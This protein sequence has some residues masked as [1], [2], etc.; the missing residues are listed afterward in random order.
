[1]TTDTPFEIFLVC[2]PGLEAPLQAEALAKGFAVSG[3]SS[4]GVT[5]TGGWPDVWRANLELRGA[6]RVLVRVGGFMAFH[7]AQLD[8]RSRKFAWGDVLRADV[9]VKVQV[10][11]K[12]SKIYH[13]GAATQRIVTALTESHGITVSADAALVVKVRIDDNQVVISLDTTGEPLHKRG[14]KQAVGKAPLRENMAAMFLAECGYDGTQVVVDPM[15]GSG[16][17]VIEAAEIAAGLQPGRSRGFAFEDLASFDADA[18]VAIRREAGQVS[19]AVQFYGSD[20]DAGAIR[21]STENAARAG[22]TEMTTFVNLSAAD[23]RPPEGPPGLVMVN[24]PYGARIGNKK[25]LYAI[26]AEFGAT[27]RTHFKGWRVGM[28]TSEPGLAKVTGLP[29]KPKG[30]PVAHGG[31]KVWLWQ[32]GVLR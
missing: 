9:P 17:F 21:M 8:K 6:V 23:A 5:V 4:G 12:A 1:M 18:F 29:W 14:H 10:T 16:T 24:P 20:R 30:A 31:M 3:A 7:L 32:T 15:C 26:Y 22:V 25:L 19:G 27:M 28:V 13:A 11:C 2:P